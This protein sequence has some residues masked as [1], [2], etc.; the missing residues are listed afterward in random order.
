MKKSLSFRIFTILYLLSAIPL[1]GY[2]AYE[3][4][5]VKSVNNPA[6]LLPLAIFLVLTVSYNIAA[7]K[8]SKAAVIEE[9]SKN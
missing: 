9:K 4:F 3:I 6:D 8:A 1:L 2:S 7:H 5:R